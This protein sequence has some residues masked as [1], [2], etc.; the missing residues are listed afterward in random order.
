M[1]VMAWEET[2]AAASAPREAARLI[3][4]SPDASRHVSGPGIQIGA[5]ARRAVPAGHGVEVMATIDDVAGENEQND[6][7]QQ[8]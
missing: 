4:S 7:H 6:E 8:R 3:T 2:G 1:S 5:R